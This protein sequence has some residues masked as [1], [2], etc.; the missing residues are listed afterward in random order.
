M[1]NGLYV[2]QQGQFYSVYLPNRVLIAQVYMGND[3]MFLLD[4]KC[5]EAITKLLGRRW[6]VENKKK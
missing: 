5:M 4:A 2:D 1:M 6:N 3:G